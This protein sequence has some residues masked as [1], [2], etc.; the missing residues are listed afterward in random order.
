MSV[1]EELL[2]GVRPAQKSAAS[3]EI[4]PDS[5]TAEILGMTTAAPAAGKPPVEYGEQTIAGGLFDMVTQGASF[6]YGD[7]MTA[8]DA[9]MFG[10]TPQGDWGE[11]GVPYGER[12]DRALAAERAQQKAFKE[13][14]PYLAL[15][16]EAAGGVASS[17]ALGAG[18][19][20]GQGV[21]KAGQIGRAA[22]GGAAGG[23]VYGFGDGE[24]GAANRL[25][26]ATIG[27]GVGA[28][29]GVAGRELA[30]GLGKLYRRLASSPSLFKDGQITDA[31]RKAIASAGFDPATVSDDFARA[32][33]KRV[34]QAGGQSDEAV[35]MAMA[36]E[37]GLPLTRGQATGDVAQIAY[38]EAARNVSRGRPAHEAVSAIDDAARRRTSEAVD[39]MRASLGGQAHE[40][41]ADAAGTVGQHVQRAASTAKDAY[42]AAYNAPAIKGASIA[43]EAFDGLP[44]LADDAL[45]GVTFSPSPQAAGAVKA[46]R[47]LSETATKGP[48]GT[49]GV[50]FQA[51]EQLRQKLNRI[52]ASDA[53]VMRE[54]SAVKGALDS[55]VDDV[56]HKS[57]ISGSPE[58]LDAVV[59]ARGKYS[60]FRKHFTKQAG[61]DIS[62]IMEKLAKPDTTPQEVANALWGYTKVGTSGTS[63]RLA[64]RLKKVLSPEDFNDVRSGL[65]QRLAQTA[66]GEV[67]TPQK[68]ATRLDDFLR[69]DGKTLA[70]HM[71]SQEERATMRRFGEA[72]KLLVPPKEATNPSKTAYAMS[73][74]VSDGWKALVTTMGMTS[75]G[76]IGAIGART[77]AESGSAVASA[78]KAAGI[79]APAP[80]RAAGHVSRNALSTAAPIAGGAQLTNQLN[81]EVERGKNPFP[82][83]RFTVD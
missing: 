37:F 19:L 68:M 54:I 15:G 13:A 64:V 76:P 20:I 22:L 42:K 55:W 36:D 78:V 53:G 60:F 27:L 51:V 61:D 44:K 29:G 14:H 40:T 39:G 7:E 79:P 71:F 49:V 47:E 57:L 69:G 48:D 21:T 31:G 2:G 73:R 80:L 5:V 72:M 45:K 83:L 58:A 43:V 81:E 62:G 8:H 18:K 26:Q 56:L 25:T 35:R 52:T 10:K 1:T 11:Y 6:G 50:S 77:A 12:Y 16:A 65:W 23:A 30:I 67:L 3:G 75:G 32:F 34:E 41:A 4:A 63:A 38:E 82:P 70:G 74:M 28:A 66:Q 17:V 33:A 9:A 24:G 46:L 59:A